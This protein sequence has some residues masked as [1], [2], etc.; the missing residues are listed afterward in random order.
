VSNEQRT[1]AWV[2]L[3]D[4]S[5]YTGLGALA[6]ADN[7]CITDAGN[8]V[9][10]TGYNAPTTILTI[11]SLFMATGMLYAVT[12][13]G[14][15]SVANNTA[16]LL[17]PMGGG[18]T[19]AHCDTPLGTI[20]TDGVVGL[21][22]NGVTAAPWVGDTQAP[23]PTLTVADLS[24]P[25]LEGMPTTPATHSLGYGN[26]ILVCV[27]EGVAVHTFPYSITT[28]NPEEYIALPSAVDVVTRVAN[29]TV[30]SSIDGTYIYNGE[31]LRKVSDYPMIQGSPVLA[32]GE[33]V[34]ANGVEVVVF[35]TTG[36]VCYVTASGEYKE[37]TS[38]R[39]SWYTSRRASAAVMKVEGSWQYV[40][41]MREATSLNAANLSDAV[42][43]RR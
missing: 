34:G 41:C 35:A 13:S 30:L 6:E 4:T 36:G 33:T 15:Y 5:D 3:V 18:K 24:E 12:P 10:R 19:I 32:D 31:S 42:A 39:V 27:T 21:V 43:F 20:V 7:V 1:T 28:L 38:E 29:I 9:S 17:S 8:I 25:R 23:D 2:G 26:G 40:I 14:L 22:V 37:L 16:T 11:H